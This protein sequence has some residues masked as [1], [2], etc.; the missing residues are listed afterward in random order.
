MATKQ[1]LG[2]NF[3]HKK[4]KKSWAGMN[5]SE[6]KRARTEYGQWKRS[7][8]G[9]QGGTYY[10]VKPPKG[11]TAASN[12]ATTA[13]KKTAAPKKTTAPTKTTTKTTPAKTHPFSA[14]FAGGKK[15]TGRVKPTG[16]GNYSGTGRVGSGSTKKPKQTAGK[17]KPTG[18]GNYAKAGWAGPKGWKFD[19]KRMDRKPSGL[20]ERS[21]WWNYQLKYNPAVRGKDGVLSHDMGSYWKKIWGK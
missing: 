15:T 16:P 4:S 14:G 7:E 10:G 18:P 8:E 17:V 12:K 13:K 21:L 2:N 9:R 6:R 20:S 5:L 1:Q 11:W 19:G 3:G